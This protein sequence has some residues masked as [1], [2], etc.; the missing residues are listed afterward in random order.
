LVRDVG[1][2]AEPPQMERDVIDPHVAFA[3]LSKIMLGAEPLNVTLERIAELARATRR[4]DQPDGGTWAFTPGLS[5][6]DR[7]R[8]V[9]FEAGSH[10]I[11]RPI[12]RS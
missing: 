1:M 9:L 11:D 3:E 2:T 12:M 6:E 7:I 8:T 5:Y 10:D 4:E